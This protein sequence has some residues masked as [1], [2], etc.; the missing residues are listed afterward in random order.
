[1]SEQKKNPLIAGAITLLPNLISAITGIIKDKKKAKEEAKETATT[2]EAVIESIKDITS[3]TISSKRLL[4]VGGFA[5]IISLAVADIT[6]HGITKLNLI[7]IA[8]GVVYSLGMSLITFL[9]ER[10]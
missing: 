6:A 8:V 1:M 4:N 2:G 10:K 5:L 7:L 3:G 9:S